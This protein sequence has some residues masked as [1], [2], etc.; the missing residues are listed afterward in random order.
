MVRPG[1]AL[2]VLALFLVALAPQPVSSAGS[3]PATVAERRVAVPRVPGEGRSGES[4]DA[5]RLNLQGRLALERLTPT[6]L[7]ESVR[8]FEQALDADPDYAPAWAGLAEALST[9][10]AYAMISDVSSR[11]RAEQAIE[12]TLALDPDLAEAWVA[13]GLLAYLDRRSPEALEAYGRAVEIRPDYAQAHTLRAFQSALQGERNQGVE[14]ARQAVR[15]NPLSAEAWANLSAGM[16][17]LGRWNEAE[18]AA[19][20]TI[21]L[22]PGWSSA[23]FSLGM[24]H[25]Y[26]GNHEAAVEQ[27]DG[28]SVPWTGAGAEVLK[29]RALVRLGRENEAR[30]LIPALEA[31]GDAYALAALDAELGNRDA[32]WDR[33]MGIETWDD[34]PTLVFRDLDKPLWLREGEQERYAEVLAR[35]DASWGIERR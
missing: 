21:D 23:R 3:D 13:R 28:L 5:Y 34:W 25:F 15:L 7:A 30:R 12:R 10:L 20:R 26:R 16:L 17:T 9:Q 14:S 22:A 27:L 29:A 8:Y 2:T 24:V 19:D 6:S 33:L 1:S 35:V 11:A 31:R 4:L 18:D 32:A